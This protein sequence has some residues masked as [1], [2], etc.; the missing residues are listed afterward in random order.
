MNEE[1]TVT[2]G[3]AAQA[4]GDG[5]RRL[6]GRRR[7]SPAACCTPSTAA[8][9]SASRRSRRS[10]CD[11]LAE[12]GA[13]FTH[14]T[15]IAPTGTISLSLAN[16]A[17]QRHRA[18]V[19]APLLPQR[20]PRRAR[21]PRRRSTSSRSSCWPIASSSI[22][23]RDAGLDERRREAAGLLHRGRRHHARAS[24]STSRPPRRSGSIRRSPRPRTCRPITRTRTSR[25]STSTP[26]RRA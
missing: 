10:W 17:S 8:T 15:S 5:A 7:R 25:T 19:R 24:T 21:S 3:D 11:E 16:N 23:K 2:E 26:T 13:R 9:C 18:V 6:E 14:H 4:S 20:D 12:I 1:F 22:R